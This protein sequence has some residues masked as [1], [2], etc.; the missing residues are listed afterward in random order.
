MQK[1]GNESHSKNTQNEHDDHSNFSWFWPL[2]V[3]RHE[4]ANVISQIEENKATDRD[5]IISIVQSP[6]FT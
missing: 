5:E 1:Q 2:D 4:S 3:Y 6:K